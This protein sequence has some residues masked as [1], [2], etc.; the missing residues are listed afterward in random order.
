MSSNAFLEVRADDMIAQKQPGWLRSL[1]IVT[2][3]L[4]IILA[5]AVLVY[6]GLGI[7]TLI[8]LLYIGLILAG[9]RSVSLIGMSFL[10]K[11]IRLIG[12]V[13]GLVS[14]VLAVVVAI[15]P[16]VAAL[17]LIILLSFGLLVYGLGRLTVAYSL[18]ASY[19]WV[20]ALVAAVGVLDVVLS[21]AVLVL[22]G[23]A[24]L[25]LVFLL[26]LVLFVSGAEILVSGALGRTWISAVLTP[27]TESTK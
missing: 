19:T 20:R 21:V 25:T 18:K 2:G 7:A 10:S 26:G 11:T 4:A 12:L 22:P 27:A 15:F 1:E 24:L 9:V 17:T 8:V 23:V 3:F 16:A 14:I 6:P 5:V 13:S